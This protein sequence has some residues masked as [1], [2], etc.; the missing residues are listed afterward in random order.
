MVGLATPGAPTRS[1]WACPH[2]PAGPC[3]GRRTM[4][5]DVSA[6]VAVEVEEMILGTRPVAVSNGIASL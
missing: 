2:C 5:D 4:Q 6:E 3:E 1:G